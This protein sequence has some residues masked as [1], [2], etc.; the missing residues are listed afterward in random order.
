M[1]MSRVRAASPR[2]L[3]RRCQGLAEG[4]PWQPP[5]DPL[6]IYTI[7]KKYSHKNLIFIAPV[8]ELYI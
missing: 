8:K 7:G 6:H 2:E 3:I 5:K 1:V 4:R